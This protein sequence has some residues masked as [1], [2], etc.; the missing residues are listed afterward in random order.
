MNYTNIKSQFSEVISYSQ[1]IAEPNI[2]KLFEQWYENKK[3][4]IELFGDKLIYEL[5]YKVKFTL[6]PNDIYKMTSEFIEFIEQGFNNYELADFVYANDTSFFENRVTH[7]YVNEEKGIFIG[8]GA[9][10]IKSFKHFEKDQKALE[11]LQNKASQIIQTDKIEGTLCLSVHPLDFL[12]SSENTYRWTSCHSLNGDYRA[13]NLSYMVD[14][15]TVLCYLK[16]DNDVKIP[17]FPDTVK[18]NS[19]KWRTLLHFSQNK[20]LILAGRQYPFPSESGLD[21]ILQAL[22]ALNIFSDSCNWEVNNDFK[23]LVQNTKNA[24]NYN[25]LLESSIYKDLLSVEITK[26]EHSP[27][28]VGEEVYCLHCG[29]KLVTKTETM[30]CDECELKYGF[31]V[32]ESFGVCACCGTRINKDETLN[33]GDDYICDTCC[34]TE[35]FICEDCGNLCYNEEMCYDTENHKMIC[36]YCYEEGEYYGS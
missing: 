16:G 25:D 11:I 31:E 26:G 30:R 2:D 10:I 34:K 23:K 14:N 1:G 19:K 17:M 18:W 12:S 13:G 8:S 24:L 36:K 7:P 27:V 15:S 3:Y 20:D 32:N 35:C 29:K 5:P 9:K 28:V 33:I 21:L 4:F 22:S 6:E